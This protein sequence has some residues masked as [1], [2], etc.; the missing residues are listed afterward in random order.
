MAEDRPAAGDRIFRLAV[1]LTF[2]L[3][4]LRLVVS[5]KIDLFFDEAYYW[6]W[7]TQLQASYYDHPGMVAFF[8]RA[9]TT[10]FGQ[11]EFGVRFFGILSATVDTFLIYGIVI[12]LSGSRRAGAWAMIAMNVSIVAIFSV[13]TVPDQPMMM[14]WLAALYGLARIAKGGQPQWWLLVGLMGGLAASSKLT[15]FFVALAVPL[16]LVLSPDMRRWFRSPWL[17]AGGALAILA[18]VPALIW[19]IQHD[20][21]AFTLQYSRP[22]FPEPRIGS[23]IQYVGLY[24]VMLTPLVMILAGAGLAVILRKGWRQDPGRA[25][26]VLTPIPLAL[27]FAYHSLGEWIGAHWLAP[28]VAV[29]AIYAGYATEFRVTGFWGKV[30]RFSFRFVVP[31]GL[32]ITAIAYGGVLETVLKVSASS[33]VTARFRG[34]DEFA[35]NAEAKREEYDAAFILSPDYSTPAY[36][37]FYLGQDTPAYQLGQFERWATFDGLGTAPAEFASMTGIYIGRWS[38]NYEEE[39]VSRYFNTIERIGDTVRPIRDGVMYEW[40]TWLVSDPK[41]EAMALFGLPA[42]AAGPVAE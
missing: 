1:L 13:I 23:L 29:G 27:Y 10:L 11:T 16:W 28:L 40:P 42:E 26:L 6:L 38:K 36:L 25:L 33:D 2:G 24:P 9:G 17:Y 19:N 7:S 39:Y 30:T 41:P 20:W 14:F 37:R 31:V 8:M 21:A 22:Q 3:L 32:A 5:T 4:A 34:W 12:T 35:A 18:F 15:T